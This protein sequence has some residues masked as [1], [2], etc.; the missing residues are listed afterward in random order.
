MDTVDKEKR[1][2]IMSSVRSKE[3][4]LEIE[5]RKSLWQ[6]GFRYRKNSRKYYGTPDIV[7]PS[8]K[9]VIFIDS[10][11]W[12]GCPRHLR[13][14]KSNKKFWEDKISRNVERDKDVTRYYKQQKW[15]I[16]RIWE[17]E[18]NKDELLKKKIEKVSKMILK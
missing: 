16:I 18:I 5:F 1:S 4:K 6:K 8:K 17:H 13:I 9:V 7:M 11:F 10:C 3:T 2:L 14:P 12:H 15:I